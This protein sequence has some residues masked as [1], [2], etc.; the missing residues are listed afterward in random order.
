MPI[1]R[2]EYREASHEVWERIA[3]NWDS[4]REYIYS[5]TGPVSK[6]IVERV[7]PQPGDT[8][9][10]LAAGTGD[11]GFLAAAMI[12][13][14]GKLISTDFAPAMVDA[15]RDVSTQLGLGN[16]EHRVLDA[17]HMNLDDSSVD[18][19]LCRFGYMLMADPA[20]ALGETRR[21]LRD[22]GRL[23]FAV[24]TT[25]DENPWAFLAGVVLVERGH[26]PAP[27]PGDPGIFAMGDP[28]RIRELVSGAGFAE[29]EIEQ[30]EIG[31]P[32]ED[33]EEHWSLTRKLAGPLA[34]AIDRL[35]EDERE[36]VRADIRSRIDPL[37]AE[38]PVPG[39]VHVVTT[40]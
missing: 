17:E 36:S 22:G 23:S 20:A 11:T 32:Y 19:V 1:D 9:L 30:V 26:L 31:W 37:I 35:D 33:A 27:E 28:E 21:V 4:E 16:V 25:P 10:D 6:R 15:A 2:D 3:V 18:R 40:T 7:D 14:E 5:V 29:P 39:R 8:V 12:G 13:G 24:W 34:D 38:G